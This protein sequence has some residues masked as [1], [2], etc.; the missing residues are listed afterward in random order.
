MWQH[1]P[2]GELF[3]QPPPCAFADAVSAIVMMATVKATALIVS[4]LV[5]AH[6]QA[7]AVPEIGPLHDRYRHA[8]QLASAAT[9][10]TASP[11]QVAVSHR[12]LTP[13]FN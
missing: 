2:G 4:S 9:A 3:L 10:L 5:P 6:A 12:P 11:P 8:L 7:I 13:S 1:W